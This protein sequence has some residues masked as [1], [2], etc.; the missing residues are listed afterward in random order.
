M[1]LNLVEDPVI[2][3][4]LSGYVQ[5]VGNTVLPTLVNVSG[6]NLNGQITL[7]GT[8][9]LAGG[10]L[11]DIDILATLASTSEIEG[12]YTL[13]LPNLATVAETGAFQVTLTTP[14]I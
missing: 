10:K 8:N 12:E 2:V 3:G 14:V 4:A 6:E 1:T 5:L 13:T 7:H 9:N 11:V